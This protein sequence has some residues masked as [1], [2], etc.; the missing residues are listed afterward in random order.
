MPEE[1]LQAVAEH[2]HHFGGVSPL[3]EQNVQL[4]QQLQTILPFPLYLG[5]R[6]WTPYVEETLKQIESD[7]HKKVLC[8]S[9][10]AFGSYSGCRQYQENLVDASKG[11]TLEIKKIRPFGCEEWFVDSFADAVK[12]TL[13]GI[14]SPHV[15]FTAH[16]I[17]TA[18]AATAPYV[19]DLE[20]VKKQIDTR[21]GLLHSNLVYQS[22]SGRPTDPW[23]EPDILHAIESSPSPHI[24]VVP[25]GFLSD[26]MEVIWD[27]DH[28]AKLKC[29]S[30]GKTYAR[31]PTPYDHPHFAKQ[32]SQ[33]IMRTGWSVKSC[34]PECCARGY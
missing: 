26:H 5:H 21:L 30:M 19:K 10:S 24:V 20:H 34:A 33:H 16:S 12:N 13:I 18:M 27:L 9:T 11:L 1:R 28:D 8:L 17:P 15:L 22:R 29:A 32:L 31:V 4:Q 7:G 3:H 2:Y 23:L 14:E 25:L 6:N